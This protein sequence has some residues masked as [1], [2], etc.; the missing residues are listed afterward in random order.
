MIVIGARP[1]VGKSALV[2]SIALHAA[3]TGKNVGI[4]SL[5]MSNAEIAS[6]LASIHTSTDFNILFR[7][8]YEDEYQAHEV[9]KRIGASTSQL[10]IYVTD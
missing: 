8:L 3:T 2:G 10:P 6:R 4:V 9:Y 5:E 7:G 1:S